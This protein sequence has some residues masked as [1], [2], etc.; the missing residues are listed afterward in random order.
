MIASQAGA[1]AMSDLPTGE[2]KRTAV[3]F[4]IL[5][6]RQAEPGRLL[7]FAIVAMAGL[8]NAFIEFPK[9][10]ILCTE[11]GFLT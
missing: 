11:N 10:L 2:T 6:N 8:A 5:P 3:P 9:V 7:V 4:T 1:H